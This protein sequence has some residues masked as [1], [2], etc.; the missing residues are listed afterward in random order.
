[1]EGREV[2]F[3]DLPSPSSDLYH[4]P[5]LSLLFK[6]TLYVTEVCINLASM[7]SLQIDPKTHATNSGR[8]RMQ[9]INSLKVQGHTVGFIFT[10]PQ[11]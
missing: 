3:F 5:P 9:I 4:S 10:F 2:S 6:Q 1:M 11:K 8:F 7:A